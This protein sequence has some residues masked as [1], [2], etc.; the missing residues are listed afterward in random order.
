[1]GILIVFSP[2]WFIHVYIFCINEEVRAALSVME[3][4]MLGC[5]M[6]DPPVQTGCFHSVVMINFLSTL[7]SSAI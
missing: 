4:E 3:E 2:P 5:V 1:M 6:K 7:Y